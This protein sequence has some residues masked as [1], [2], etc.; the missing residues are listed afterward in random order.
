MGH[1]LK[2]RQP[3]DLCNRFYD[4]DLLWLLRGLKEVIYAECPV[5]SCCVSGS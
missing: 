4:A 2:G 1:W 5:P 3:P